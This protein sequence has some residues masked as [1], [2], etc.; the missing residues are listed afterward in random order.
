MDKEVDKRLIALFSTIGVAILGFLVLAILVLCDYKF[1]IDGFNNVVANNRNGFWTGF[2]KIFTHLGVFYVVAGL[3]LVGAILL[4]FVAKNKRMSLFMLACFAFTCIA[5]FILKRV[6]RRIRPEHLMLIEESGFSF[7][8]GHSMMSF[9][10]FAMLIYF[11]YKTIKNKVFKISLISLCAVLTIM[12][13]F[14]RIYL[15]VHYLTD[16]LAGWLITLAVVLTFIW[17]YNSNLFRKKEDGKI[18]NEVE[19][20]K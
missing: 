10:L 3:V 14:S 9:V 12:V 7:P 18:K 19:S 15:G 17:A 16:I 6:I 4:W 20:G 8:S 11:V 1:K 13:G 5:N 2:F